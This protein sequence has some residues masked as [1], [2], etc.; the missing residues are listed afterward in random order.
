MRVLRSMG[1]VVLGVVVLVL[2]SCNTYV[3]LFGTES[4]NPQQDL[5]GSWIISSVSG[6]GDYSEYHA[7]NFYDDDTFTITNADGAAI[8][9]DDMSEITDTSFRAVIITQT[10]YPEYIGGDNY[11]EYVI[12]TSG[13]DTVLR[14]AFF[15][16][17]TKA[18]RFVTF[19]GVKE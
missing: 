19:V 18:T 8:E 16:D 11:A 1:I 14:V 12:K 10:V 4:A 2:G 7:L 5:I 9:Q 15:D 17:E 3:L 13:E 6:A